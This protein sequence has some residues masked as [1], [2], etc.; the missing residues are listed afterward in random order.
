MLV[1]WISNTLD[2]SVRATIGE[3]D[4]AQLL[5]NNRKNRF[6]VVSGT[7]IC[8]LK[9]SL[10][11]CKQGKTDSIAVY[12]GRIAKIWDELHTYLTVSSCS[13]GA[14]KCNI[15]AQ[16]KRLRQ[17]DIVHHFLIGLDDAYA[18][19]RGQLLAQD[20][21]PTVDKAYQQLIQAERL[22]GGDTAI[23]SS[24]ENAMAFKVQHDSSSKPSRGS[25]NSDKLCIYCN[26]QGHDESDCYQ[27]NGYPPWWGDRTRGGRGRGRGDS[28]TNK[29]GRGGRGG[30]RGNSA[31]AAP[32][33]ANKTGGQAASSASSSATA[34]DG[35]A[36]SGVTSAQIQQI[37][38]HLANMK[39]KLQGPNDEE[40]DWSG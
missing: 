17:E 21:I 23:L 31:T 25:E 32:V 4:D 19:L 20:P 3:Y 38:E 37:I 36:L 2:S 34:A 39:P 13:C 9:F 11:E 30:G 33:R 18:S 24:R 12:F 22:R 27:L 7:R 35:A 26:R 5:W 40:G 15:V 10:G 28:G 8:Q 14:C 16:V 29:G 6:C 1:A